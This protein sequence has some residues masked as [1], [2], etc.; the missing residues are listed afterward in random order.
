MRRILVGMV[1]SGWTMSAV[2]NHHDHDGYVQ[3]DSRS[4]AERVQLDTYE[5]QTNRWTR[6]RNELSEV[7][8]RLQ[9]AQQD[10]QF[11]QQQ[12]AQGGQLYAQAQQAY[13]PIF[14]QLQPAMHACNMGNPQACWTVN[15]LRPQAAFLEQQM[16]NANQIGQESTQRYY[17]AVNRYNSLVPRH[18]DI[19]R[20]LARE[21]GAERSGGS[22]H[23]EEVAEVL[24]PEV[25]QQ[26]QAQSGGSADASVPRIRERDV[27]NALAEGSGI[28]GCVGNEVWD[29]LQNSRNYNRSQWLQTG[30]LQ[31]VGFLVDRFVRAS[32]GGFSGES[33]CSGQSSNGG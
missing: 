16:M 8:G 15:Q 3:L 5:A 2:A 19:Q 7:E 4:L 24:L 22:D 33:I 32:Q 17:N 28:K 6:L 26:L 11:A 25:R 14:Q 31:A 1:L 13:M 29:F 20:Q 21:A 27:Y 30:G 9:Q 18:M 12:Y 10:A 23:L